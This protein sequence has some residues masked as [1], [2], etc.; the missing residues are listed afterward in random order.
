MLEKH[1]PAAFGPNNRLPGLTHG[2]R[3]FWFPLREP[4]SFAS[5]VQK[6]SRVTFRPRNVR[7][8]REY[9]SFSHL[10]ILELLVTG[11]RTFAGKTFIV[12]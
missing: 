12:V 11:S 3:G 5:Q 8:N 9:G 6:E 10:G 2:R 7:A 4:N 1:Q